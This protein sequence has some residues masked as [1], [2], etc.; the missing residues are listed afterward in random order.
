MSHAQQNDPDERDIALARA[1]ARALKQREAETAASAVTGASAPV[2]AEACPP[3]ELL[4]AYAESALD[5][6]ETAQWE[7]HFAMCSR[8]RTVLSVLAASTDE[9]LAESEVLRLGEVV[10]AATVPGVRA[11]KQPSPVS[12]FPAHWR[13]LAPAIGV[14]AA[15]ALFFI[16]RPPPRFPSAAPQL[17]SNQSAENKMEGPGVLAPNPQSVAKKLEAPSQPVGEQLVCAYHEAGRSH[18][19]R[20]DIATGK[21]ALLE[22]PYSEFGAI[23]VASGRII[24]RAG[25]PADP[26]AIIAIDPATGAVEVLRQSAPAEALCKPRRHAP[27]PL[28]KA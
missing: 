19:A 15:G 22:V 12:R 3:A 16:L 17:A 6:H 28:R 5:A 14:A 26:S 8:C 11:P 18:L 23:R 9:P 2:E 7:S 1:L 21:L 4:A 24:C 20:L 10:A 25:S 27:R 13:W